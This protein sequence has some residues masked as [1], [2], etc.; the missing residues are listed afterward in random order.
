MF[1]KIKARVHEI[2][3]MSVISAMKGETKIMR[4]ELK[5]YNIDQVSEVLADVG[6]HNIIVNKI[7]LSGVK[8]IVINNCKEYLD[9]P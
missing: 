3:N 4:F 1:S 5:K 6:G 2:I 8:K 9:D 7:M